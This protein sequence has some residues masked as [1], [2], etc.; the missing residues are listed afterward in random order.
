MRAHSHIVEGLDAQTEVIDVAALAAG[1]RPAGGAELARQRDEIDEAAAGA[2]LH[3]TDLVRPAVH[4]AAER[5]AVERERSGEVG[6]ARA[7]AA[8]LG[9]DEA[10]VFEALYVTHSPVEDICARFSMTKVALYSFRTRLKRLVAG[11]RT[12]V[13]EPFEIAPAP[14]A[15]VFPESAE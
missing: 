3:E 8:S 7:A 5:V 10:Q 6:Y 9:A 15:S 1:T 11:F 2:Q 13:E 14:T 12:H 4:R